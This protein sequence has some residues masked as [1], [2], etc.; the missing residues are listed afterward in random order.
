MQTLNR[1][2]GEVGVNRLCTVACEHCKVVNLS[3]TAGLYHQT[4]RGS[5]TFFDEVL[6]NR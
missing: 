3:G 6:M 5:E 2:D 4:C 1:L